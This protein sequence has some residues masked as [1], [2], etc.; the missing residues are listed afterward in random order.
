MLGGLGAVV[1]AGCSIT[2]EV[3]P[4]GYV[5]TPPPVERVRIDP[6]FR[7]AV[8]NSGRQARAV[9]FAPEYQRPEAIRAALDALADAIEAAP[10]GR[11]R[12][13]GEA[14][15]QIRDNAERL[16]YEGGGRH[17]DSGAV[18]DALQEATDALDRLAAGPFRRAGEVRAHVFAL[19]RQVDAIRPWAPLRRQGELIT[20]ALET[21]AG[22]LEAMLQATAR[23]EAR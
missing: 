19:R 9:R 23:G 15:A 17:A 11:R 8:V 7:D 3:P 21:A 18:V 6:A 1:L 5:R 2:A 13:I 12:W 20:G 16:G 14:A 22:A 10:D 4:A